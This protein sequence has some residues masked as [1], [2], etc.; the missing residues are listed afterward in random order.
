LWRYSPA[1]LPQLKGGSIE[2]GDEGEPDDAGLAGQAAHGAERQEP[3]CRLLR[4]RNIAGWF[5]A[6]K[7]SGNSPLAQVSSERLPLVSFGCVTHEQHFKGE[8]GTK[9]LA[10]KQKHGITSMDVPVHESSQD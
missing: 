8:G 6:Q 2:F 5:T 4:M 7:E 9:P 3:P 10:L 1:A